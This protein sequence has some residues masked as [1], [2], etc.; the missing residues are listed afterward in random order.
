MIY[1]LVSVPLIALVIWIAGSSSAANGSS[2]S[3]S[4]RLLTDYAR[5]LRDMPNNHLPQGRLSSAPSDLELKPGSSVL[6]SDQPIAYILDLDRSLSDE[7]RVVQPARLGWSITM[8]LA[9]VN[10][11]GK[12]I[13][14]TH[15]RRWRVDTLRYPERRLAIKSG[16]GLYRLSVSIERFT[17][18][19]L[20]SYHQ[21]IR[22]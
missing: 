13:A 19:D 12:P 11:L 16:P 4:D 14:I 3:C 18:L 2:F 20:A 15:Q 8:R 22:V 21:F 5:V 1:K 10:R 17:G 7:G 9:S 6:V